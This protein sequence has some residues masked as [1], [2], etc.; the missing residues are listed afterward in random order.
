MVLET[1]KAFRTVPLVLLS[2]VLLVSMVGCAG[3]NQLTET[4]E[5]KSVSE[6]ASANT[7][8]DISWNTVI[9]AHEIFSMEIPAAWEINTNLD[10]LDEEMPAFK[11]MATVPY[12]TAVNPETGSNILAY[13][14]F[15][16]A[17]AEQPFSLDPAT[18]VQLQIE[19][20]EK[21][22]S[23][24]GAIQRTDIAIDGVNGSQLRFPKEA[25][26]FV[27]NILIGNENN[28][29]MY[30]GQ[31]AM[32]FQ[33]LYTTSVEQKLIEDALA[34]VR[35]L[36]TAA[37]DLES[38]DQLAP[39]EPKEV[40]T[41]TAP[42]PVAPKEV[43]KAKASQVSTGI[44]EASKLI[45]EF[46]SNAVGAST[47]YENKEISVKGIISDIGTDTWTGQTYVSVGTDALFEL[48]EIRCVVN[49]PS[50]VA[51]L[52]KGSPITITGT[53]YEYDGLMYIDI[54]PCSVVT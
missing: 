13:I 48:Y 9:D 30:C 32:V 16:A 4:Q 19:D 38:C 21:N 42:A 20:F 25:V 54:T 31:I 23:P 1:F 41:A 49:N 52:S 43:E 33:G 10:K 47:K 8:Q 36:P 35:I 26:T 39:A 29:L 40:E 24:T 53:F 17:L 15:Q 46:D 51:E 2:L 5:T 50:E 6:P 12:L 18:Y 14:D 28:T 34:S 3:E 27:M 7:S 11:A 37:G 45:S 22:L 44:I